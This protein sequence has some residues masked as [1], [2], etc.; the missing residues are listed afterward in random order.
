MNIQNRLKAFFLAANIEY[1]WHRILRHREAGN[2]LLAEG[3][4]LNSDRML[5]LNRRLMHHTLLAM[6][7][8]K[9]YEMHFVP[10]VRGNI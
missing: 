6:K 7:R 1:H 3:A 8:E 2:R 10:P 9:Y 4:A 5:R